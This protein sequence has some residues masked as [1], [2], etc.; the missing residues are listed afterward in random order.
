MNQRRGPQGTLNLRNVY[1][2][3]PLTPGSLVFSLLQCKVLGNL[4]NDLAGL[5]GEGWYSTWGES[6]PEQIVDPDG[7]LAV[8]RM[9]SHLPWKPRKTTL[10]RNSA[11]GKTCLLKPKRSAGRARG[12]GVS[13]RFR[14]WAENQDRFMLTLP[15]WSF[16]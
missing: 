7:H 8:S 15:T 16:G 6:E 1:P 13:M 9:P 5:L 3:G 2:G 4:P 10:R 11:L 14:K 12:V